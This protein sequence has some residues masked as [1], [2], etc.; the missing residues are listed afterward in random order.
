M[1]MGLPVPEVIPDPDPYPEPVPDPEPWA[2]SE[3]VPDPEMTRKNLSGL[4]LNNPV[5]YEGYPFSAVDLALDYIENCGPENQT[6]VSLMDDIKWLTRLQRSIE[7]IC[8]RK[9]AEVTRRQGD[10]S[11]WLQSQL[12]VTGNQATAMSRCAR[13]VDEEL[14]RVAAAQR[15]GELSQ[16]HVSIIC[17]ALRE[18]E[19]TTLEPASLEAN[20]VAA[21][22]EMDPYELQRYWF[23]LRY[24]RDQESGVEAEEANRNR[25]WLYLRQMPY[26]DGYKLEAYLDAEGG[27]TLK[28]ALKAQAGKPA[29]DD[30]RTPARRQADALVELAEHR[31]NSGDLPL[32]GGERPHVT[33]VASVETLRLE[34]G[35]PMA[36]L[37]WGHLVTGDSARRISCDAAVSPVLVGPDDEILHAGRRTR[38]VSP[39]KRRALNLRDQGC[40]APGCTVPP[41][42][43]TP[44]HRIHWADGGPDELWNL[45]LRCGWHHT[46]VHPE[47]ARFRDRGGG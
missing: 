46:E 14:P 30:E 13:Q 45:E 41:E 25:R 21:A 5:T 35:S 38:T 39:A 4:R 17:K 34:P 9:L 19:K 23:Q 6:T 40:V 47:N 16:Q 15:R 3:L 1:D 10:V 24:R 36:R 2:M 18:V 31:L 26:E 42:E 29:P 7:G 11:W 32:H 44:H 22:A 37:D 28:T 27:S 33:L 43:C 12:R 8:S 20:L